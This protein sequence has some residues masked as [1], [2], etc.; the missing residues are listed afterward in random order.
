MRRRGWDKCVVVVCT[1]AALTLVVSG[2]FGSGSSGKTSTTR[3][4]KSTVASTGGTT[5]TSL[6]AATGTTIDAALSTFRS[7]D[8]FI[9]QAQAT[10]STTAGAGGTTATTAKGTVTTAKTT[11]TTIGTS[12][13][14]GGG[15]TTSSTGTSNSTS[16]TTSTTAPHLHTM[17]I[18]SVGQVA[19][20]PAVTFQVDGSVYKDRH[21]GDVISS[22]W[23]HIK[24]LEV[25]LS[26]KVVTLLQGSETLVLSVGQAI[27]Q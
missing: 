5:S 10:T 4:T 2:C 15:A 25:N 26:S 27:F 23:G 18:L 3:N 11:L 13:G 12:G 19:G 6:G 8:P 14:G 24:V 1:V 17:K 20:A 21:V 16:S 9:Q 7:K 22:N